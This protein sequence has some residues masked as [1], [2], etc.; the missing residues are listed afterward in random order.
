LTFSQYRL[1]RFRH[2]VAAVA[3]TKARVR[4]DVDERRAQLVELGLTAFGE[5]PY[6]EVAVED[7]ARSAGIS[8]GLLFHYFP[9]KKAFYVA[10]LRASAARLLAKVEDVPA[11]A[12]PLEQLE[13]SLDAYLEFVH[14]RG[15]AYATLMRGAGRDREVGA[16]VD[17]TRRTLLESLT[18]GIAVV[19][20]E[21]ASRGPPPLL[22][23][24]LEGW[25]GLAETT[26]IA[27]VERGETAPSARSVRDL[28]VR[29]LVTLVEAAAAPRR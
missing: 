4:L 16:V 15:R 28:L 5:R 3:K 10:C 27:W 14:A 24:A 1:D 12:P 8:K 7:I 11:D 19:F 6:D 25:I 23:L 13:R 21:S 20:P 29:A 26:S 18:S 2:I 22:E 9:T 17:E